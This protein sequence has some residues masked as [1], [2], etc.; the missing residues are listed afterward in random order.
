MVRKM[1][2]VIHL[3]LRCTHRTVKIKWSPQNMETSFRL[4]KGKPHDRMMVLTVASERTDTTALAHVVTKLNSGSDVL[5]LLFGVKRRNVS[6]CQFGIFHDKQC[7]PKVVSIV[8][9]FIHTSSN[10]Q[11]FFHTSKMQYEVVLFTKCQRYLKSG[12]KLIS[13]LLNFKTSVENLYD[14]TKLKWYKF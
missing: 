12:S 5:S 14:Q 7:F 2:H 1:T 11:V 8:H 4:E 13:L 9:F 10:G 6:L 3:W